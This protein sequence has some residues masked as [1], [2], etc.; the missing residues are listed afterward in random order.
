M[1]KFMI[2]LIMAM[3]LSAP[4]FASHKSLTAT[5][6]GMVCG[7]CAQGIQKKFSAQAAVEKIDVSLAEKRVTLT[8]KDGQDISDETVTKLLT[9]SG[10]NVEKIARK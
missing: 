7:F 1:R 9:E 4:A 3:A 2:S 5:V 10:Y 6:K 8:L